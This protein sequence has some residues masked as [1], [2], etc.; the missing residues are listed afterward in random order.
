MPP[1]RNYSDAAKDPA[2]Q[3]GWRAVAHPERIRPARVAGNDAAQHAPALA[4]VRLQ[5]RVPG[6]HRGDHDAGA[7]RTSTSNKNGVV[8][9]RRDRTRTGTATAAWDAGVPDHASRSPAATSRA[10]PNGA[11]SNPIARRPAPPRRHRRG[12]RRRGRPLRRR[13]RT[14]RRTPRRSPTRTA[15]ASARSPSRSSTSTANGAR[16][17]SPSRTR[18]STATACAAAVDRGPHRPNGNG[19]F[20]PRGAGRAVHG[21]ERERPLGRGGAVTGTATATAS[22]NG[23]TT[24]DP[25]LARVEPRDRQRQP[26]AT[27]A[28]IAALRRAVP[29]TVNANG[30]WNAAE[31]F[32]DCNQNGVLGRRLRRAARCGSRRRATPRTKR[33]VVD[34]LRHAARDARDVA[35]DRGPRR[36]S[37][38][39]TTSTTSRARRPTTAAAANRV[40][41]RPRDAPRHVPEEHGALDRRDPARRG[42]RKAFESA[43]GRE[44][45]RRRRPRSSRSDTR[46]A[47]TSRRARCGPCANTPQNVS[48]AYAGTS[49]QPRDGPVQRALPVPGRPAP[50]PVRRPT[51]A[52]RARRSRTATTGSSTTSTNGTDATRHRGSRF[53]AARLQRAAGWAAARPTTCR[54]TCHWLRTAHHEDRGRLH[55]A[56]GLLVLLPL[57]RRRRRLRRRERLR[58]TASRWTGR[59]S[60]WRGRRERGHDHRRRRHRRRSAGSQ[61]YVREQ[62]RRPRPASAPAATGGASRGSASSTRTR[63]TPGSGR[64]GATC[65]RPRAPR[66]L[67]YRLIRRGDVPAAQQPRGTTLV[68]R[69]RAPRGRGL[70]VA[71]STSAPRPARST[72][73]TRTARRAALDRGRPAARGEL[74]L[75]APHERARD[76]PPVR[77][78]AGRSGGV[79]DRVRA[80]RPSTRASPR[81]GA[82]LLRPPERR[83]RAA[84]SCAC[85]SRAARRARRSSS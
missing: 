68:E 76:Q 14:R 57:R 54:A 51:D 23:P 85:A 56:H 21:H 83:T 5:D 24:P 13:S 52:H 64:R 71:S 38:A 10:N 48:R 17:A 62:Q 42:V 19:L 59:R 4:R 50:L 73:R 72:T 75:P 35:D 36:R 67:E 80:T 25:A 84:A 81:D 40:R 1:V 29:S 45:R 22:R 60:A 20:D 11:A 26:A 55:D 44:Q 47:P 49:T 69:V 53:D 79:G 58:R 82:S 6:R 37:A 46:S 33:T 12:R 8:R 18:T 3:P 31:A 30:T 61:K 63:P 16:G 7:S 65:A 78:R 70:H 32:F 15:T 43:A 34:A 74:Q 2:S 41:A 27:T 9:R 66:A 77:P 28:Y 39:S